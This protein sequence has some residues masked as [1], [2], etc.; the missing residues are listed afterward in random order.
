VYD[1]KFRLQVPRVRRKDTGEEVP[2][3]SFS[4][5]RLTTALKPPN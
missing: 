4:Q 1:Q 5:L 3:Q 2:T